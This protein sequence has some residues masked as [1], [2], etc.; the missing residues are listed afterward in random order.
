MIR[1]QIQ[2]TEEQSQRLKKIA[3]RRGVSMAELVRQGVDV[4]L[5]AE[6]AADRSELKERALQAAGKF[7]SGRSDVSTRH[8]RHLAETYGE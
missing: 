2:M 6:T 8:D 4:I 1:T 7:R 5:A 3:A